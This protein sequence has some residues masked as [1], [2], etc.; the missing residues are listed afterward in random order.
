MPGA[1]IVAMIIL[2][3]IANP[4]VVSIANPTDSRRCCLS[5]LVNRASIAQTKVLLFL[6]RQ[7]G[8]NMTV[9][10]AAHPVVM[11]LSSIELIIVYCRE[12]DQCPG[13]PGP[14]GKQEHRKD[15]VCHTPSLV[16][17]IDVSLQEPRMMP[18]Q[19]RAA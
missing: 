12:Q 3:I 19:S 18:W 2:V 6:K 13:S 4:I 11:T 8:V 17:M 7:Q 9:E 16:E 14:C 15:T 1:V 5:N 10:G